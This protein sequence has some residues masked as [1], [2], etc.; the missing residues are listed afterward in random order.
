MI[1]VIPTIP[2]TG[3]MF[4]VNEIF[5]D[6]PEM[7]NPKRSNHGKIFMHVYPERLPELMTLT[8]YP[9]IS[10]LRHPAKVAGSWLARK[11][12]LGYLWSLWDV[13]MGLPV[14]HFLPIDS[15]TRESALKRI[16]DYKT[17]WPVI[18][19]LGVTV[20]APQVEQKYVDF[21]AATCY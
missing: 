18:A 20:E 1:V 21:Y 5:K 4:M 9:W 15:D 12:D 14:D 17:D 16:G 19:S 11:K 3:S 6:L 7:R 8:D 2:H 10:P 13:M